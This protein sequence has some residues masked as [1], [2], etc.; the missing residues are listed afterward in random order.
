MSKNSKKF[1]IFGLILAVLLVIFMYSSVITDAVLGL[2]GKGDDAVLKPVAVVEQVMEDVKLKRSISTEWNYAKIK[3]KLGVMDSLATGDSSMS[4]VK[5]NNGFDFSLLE[6]S[7]VVIEDPKD[8]DPNIVAISLTSG[9]VTLD[10]GTNGAAVVRLRSG[11]K[12][13]EVKGKAA[14]TIKVDKATGKTKVLVRKGQAKVKDTF[15]NEETVSAGETSSFTASPVEA[16]T[17]IVAPPPPPPVEPAP[18]VQPEP[19]PVPVVKEEPKPARTLTKDDIYR[20]LAKHGNKLNAC[21]DKRIDFV[22]GR[23][24][25][26]SVTIDNMGKVLAIKTLKSETKDKITDVCLRNAVRKIKFPEF[27]G[28]PVTEN[29]HLVFSAQ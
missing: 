12:V 27:D 4:L 16:P 2:F 15:G 23:R 28:K 1:I 5:F 25:L 26:I 6:K 20:T 7:L 18:L 10:N 24:L 29:I 11:D 22:K 17:P 21:Y 8:A 14:A 13:I 3:K 19:V 9:S